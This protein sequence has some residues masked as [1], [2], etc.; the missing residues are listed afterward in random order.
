[1]DVGVGGGPVQS[2]DRVLTHPHTLHRKMVVQLGEY[3]STGIPVKL[4]RTPGN[5]YA[6][7]PEYNQHAHEI[8]AQMKF[9]PSDIVALEES[10]VVRRTRKRHGE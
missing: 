5:V 8:L 6:P 3:R 2:V 9:S 10:G 7:P 4:S 1:M